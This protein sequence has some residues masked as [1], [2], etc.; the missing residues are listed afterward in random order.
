[1]LDDALL[2]SWGNRATSVVEIR[3]PAGTVVY[4]GVA[5]PQ[6]A[7]PGG[8]PSALLGGGQQVLIPRVDPGWV[9]RDWRF[10][11]P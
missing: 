8:A 2:P 9:V 3:V 10:E 11:P 5:G 7:V 4:E 6:P 1:M